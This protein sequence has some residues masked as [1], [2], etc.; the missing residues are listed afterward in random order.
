[1]KRV[2]VFVLIALTFCFNVNFHTSNN[3]AYAQEIELE[4]EVDSQLGDL[5]FSGVEDVFNE[6]GADGNP[7][8]NSSSFFDKINVALRQGV[9]FAVYRQHRLSL[10]HH[11]HV[12]L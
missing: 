9:L 11:P 8:F 4:E 3:I 12:M 7:I 1:M 2:F 6:V 10:E 5:D